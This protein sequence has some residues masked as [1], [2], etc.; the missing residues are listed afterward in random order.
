MPSANPLVTSPARVSCSLKARIVAAAVRL[1]NR[2]PPVAGAEQRRVAAHKQQ[3]RWTGNLAQQWRIGR[4]GNR[5]KVVRWI[6]EPDAFGFVLPGIRTG[7]NGIDWGLVTVE[8]GQQFGAR[9]GI[10]RLDTT[11][12]LEQVPQTGATTGQA[13][14]VQPWNGILKPHAQSSLGNKPGIHAVKQIRACVRRRECEL[15][16]W[17]P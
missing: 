15:V 6:V 5:D 2:P 4:I 12:M 16:G 3:R 1:R 7:E 11:E 8:E 13:V 17:H 10:N 14:Q 9:C